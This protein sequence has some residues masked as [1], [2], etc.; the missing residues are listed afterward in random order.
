MKKISAILVISVFMFML[1]KPVIP[2]V[3]YLFRKDWIIEKLC[4]NREKPEMQ[5]NGKCHLEKQVSNQADESDD[6]SPD[7][8]RPEN[9]VI[10]EYLVALND[11][12]P[13]HQTPILTGEQHQTRYTFQFI[14]SI[15][16]PPI[17]DDFYQLRL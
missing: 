11:Q 12:E 10:L 5:C 15:F 6:Q 17:N 7:Q 9:R 2:Y 1:V 3:N 16:R 13:I 4:I 8:P 14:P